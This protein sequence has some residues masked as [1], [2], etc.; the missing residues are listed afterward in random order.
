MRGCTLAP[1]LHIPATA[2][3]LLASPGGGVRNHI[4]WSHP[5]VPLQLKPHEALVVSCLIQGDAEL[6]RRASGATPP[7]GRPTRRRPITAPQARDPRSSAAPYRS[8]AG[9]RPPPP[10]LLT[11]G[12]R[13]RLRWGIRTGGAMR[14]HRCVPPLPTKVATRLDGQ[15]EDLPWRRASAVD[16]RAQVHPPARR[17]SSAAGG[18]KDDV[19]QQ[20]FLL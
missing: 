7:T 18:D 15:G 4:P 13:R 9:P 8:L 6:G 11:V 12:R 19:N 14:G 17:A 3:T 5:I 1:A 20:I 16:Q 10:P 2:C